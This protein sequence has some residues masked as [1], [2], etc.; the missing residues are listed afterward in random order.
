MTHSPTTYSLMQAHEFSFSA[1]L[2][3]I[4]IYLVAI[5][6]SATQELLMVLRRGRCSHYVLISILTC[7]LT[8]MIV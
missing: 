4:S 5:V 7:S 3:L 6:G 1:L 2:N 8:A